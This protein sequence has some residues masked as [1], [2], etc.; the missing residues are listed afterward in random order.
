MTI[1]QLIAKKTDPE[2]GHSQGQRI[3]P[4]AK[5]LSVRKK[6]MSLQMVG[7]QME[8]TRP[9]PERINKISRPHH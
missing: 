1:H 9:S 7:C 4:V 3:H 2:T 6:T 8:Y 5:T